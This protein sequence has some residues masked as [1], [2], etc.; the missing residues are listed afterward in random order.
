MVNRLRA[1]IGQDGLRGATDVV[2]IVFCCLMTDHDWTVVYD[3][4]Q[5][6]HGTASTGRT[7]LP[8]PVSLLQAV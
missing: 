6:A 1:T 8:P 7:E 5:R 4:R 3:D 2:V